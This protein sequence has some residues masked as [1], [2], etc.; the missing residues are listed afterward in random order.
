MTQNGL[1]ALNLPSSRVYK[2]K[3]TGTLKSV[4]NMAFIRVVCNI[5]R[6]RSF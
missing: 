5:S 3:N 2:N 1:M 6:L 4:S